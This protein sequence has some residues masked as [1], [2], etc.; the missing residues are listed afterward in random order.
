MGTRNYARRGGGGW[1][2]QGPYVPGRRSDG[3]HHRGAKEKRGE[4]LLLA[5]VDEARETWDWQGYR[6]VGIY[7]RHMGGGYQLTMPVDLGLTVTV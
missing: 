6:V 4:S 5:L 3:R 2:V 7:Q 1:K